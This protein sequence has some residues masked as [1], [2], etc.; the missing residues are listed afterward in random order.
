[1]TCECV[2]VAVV[3]SLKSSLLLIPHFLGEADDIISEHYDAIDYNLD[4]NGSEYDD[5]R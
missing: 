4:F 3:L 1:M 5:E 2:C